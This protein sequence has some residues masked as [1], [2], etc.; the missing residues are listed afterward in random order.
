MVR[1]RTVMIEVGI[2]RVEIGYN[3]SGVVTGSGAGIGLN[4]LCCRARV[5]HLL[6]R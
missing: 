6:A 5:P 3:S 4:L 1:I 2:I